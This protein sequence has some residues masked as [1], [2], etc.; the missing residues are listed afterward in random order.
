MAEELDRSNRQ[1]RR[2]FLFYVAYIQQTSYYMWAI[3]SRT[4]HNG[5]YITKELQQHRSATTAFIMYMM[6]CWIYSIPI[7]MGVGVWWWCVG[8]LLATRQPHSRTP[9]SSS[10]IDRTDEQHCISRPGLYTYT[11]FHLTA[12]T[13]IVGALIRKISKSHSYSILFRF[14][15]SI[16]WS[17]SCQQILTVNIDIRLNSKRFNSKSLYTYT[18]R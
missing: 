16:F 1:Q 15:S 13:F 4:L 8:Q 6:C 12:H 5:E 3:Y 18:Y 11:T 7:Y 2:L 10:N 14:Y 9:H 17:F